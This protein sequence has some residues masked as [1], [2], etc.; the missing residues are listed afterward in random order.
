MSA[1]ARVLCGLDGG[2]SGFDLRLGD[3]IVL[4]LL[5]AHEFCPSAH[6]TKTGRL[7]IGD[8]IKKLAERPTFHFFFAQTA[9]AQL[10]LTDIIAERW[11]N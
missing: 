6:M 3:A 10:P 1:E 4:K 7:M 2:L 9:C 11:L 5:S 8:G